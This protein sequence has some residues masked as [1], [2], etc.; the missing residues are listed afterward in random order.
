M[1]D[2]LDDAGL[3]QRLADRA[4]GS[5]ANFLAMARSISMRQATKCSGGVNAASD[6]VLDFGMAREV[7]K[8]MQMTDEQILAED[9]PAY[10]RRQGLRIRIPGRL[11]TLQEQELEL[12]RR[13]HRRHGTDLLIDKASVRTVSDEAERHLDAQPL[14]R[15]EEKEFAASTHIRALL[16][17]LLTQAGRGEGMPETGDTLRATPENMAVMKKRCEVL[18]RAYDLLARKLEAEDL[19]GESTALDRVECVEN[20]LRALF[21]GT[22]VF[23][24]IRY[25][26]APEDPRGSLFRQGGGTIRKMGERIGRNDPC[27]CGSGCKYKRCCGRPQN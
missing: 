3:P 4:Y 27:P 7:T 23:P 12:C 20:T 9:W 14:L 16:G 13:A 6:I 21:L 2:I 19:I 18:R 24:E 17:Q 22:S 8:L 25:H 5:A 10:A 26:L 11:T 15:N 1:P